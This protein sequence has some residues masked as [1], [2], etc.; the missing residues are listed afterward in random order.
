MIVWSDWTG[1]VSIYL[2]AYIFG[3][4]KCGCSLTAS[5]V[6]LDLSRRFLGNKSDFRNYIRTDR[7]SISAEKQHKSKD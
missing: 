6:F 4:Q 5:V 7:S 1:L 2:L 3:S